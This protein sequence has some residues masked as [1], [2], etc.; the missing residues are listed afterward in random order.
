MWTG[1]PARADSLTFYGSAGDGGSGTWSPSPSILDWLPQGSTSPVPWNNGGGTTAVF[2]VGTDGTYAVTVDPAGVNAAGITFNNSGYALGG[3]TINLAG[4]AVINAASSNDSIAAVLRGAGTGGVTYTGTT[5]TVTVTGANTYAGPTAITGGTLSIATIGNG[6]TAGSLGAS[7][8]AS[9]N[10]VLSGGTLLYTGATGTTDRGITFGGGTDTLNVSN[11][12]GVL[13]FGGQAVLNG[14]SFLK[15]GAGTVAFTNTAGTNMLS[16]G[17]ANLYDGTVALSGSTTFGGALYLGNNPNAAQLNS[18]TP[19]L[20]VSAGTTTITSAS[21]LGYYAFNFNNTVVSTLN[22]TNTGVVKFLGGLSTSVGYAAGSGGLRFP[23]ND[24]SV[25]NLSGSGQIT[26]ENVYLDTQNATGGTTVNMSGS[27]TFSAGFMIVGDTGG[28]AGSSNATF[29]Q[30]GGT[31]QITG[32]Y[33]LVIAQNSISQGGDGYPVYGVYNLGNGPSGSALLVAPGVAGGQG[34]STFNINNGILQA[35]ANSSSSTSLINN[36][37]TANIMAGGAIINSNGFNVSIPQPL[38]NGDGGTGGLT[39]TGAGTLI[40]SGSN[41]YGGTTVV[42]GGTLQLGSNAAVPSGTA[43]TVNNGG[44]FAFGGVA[45]EPVNGTATGLTLGGLNAAAGSSTLFNLS[46]ASADAVAISSAANVASG[47]TISLAVPSGVSPTLG[48]YTLFQDTAGGL[49]N[50][51]LAQST[52]TMPGVT[53]GLSLAATPKSDI[54][55]ISLLQSS[56]YYFTGAAGNSLAAAGNY[57]LDA[58]GTIAAGAVPT[59]GIDVVFSASNLNATNAATTLGGLTAV[60][61]LDFNTATAITVAG[62]GTLSLTGGAVSFNAGTGIV[63]DASSAAPTIS[64][65]LLLP[66]TTTFI[67]NANA[68][69]AGPALISGVISDNSGSTGTASG[70]TLTSNASSGAAGAFNLSGANTFTGPVNVSGGANLIVAKFNNGL[71]AGPLGESS[72]ASSNVLLTNG[73]TLT[74]TGATATTDRGITFGVPGA[75]LAPN[76][77]NVSSPAATLTFASPVVSNPSGSTVL[78]GKGTVALA[79]TSAANTFGANGLYVLSGGLTLGPGTTTTTGTFYVGSNGPSGQYATVPANAVVTLNA[80]SLTVSGTNPLLMGQN[81]G[82]SHTDTLNLTNGSVLSVG[83]TVNISSGATSGQ[84]G[85]AVLTVSGGSLFNSSSTV[86][87]GGDNVTASGA[88]GTFNLSDTSRATLGSASST[89]YVGYGTAGSVGTLNLTGSGNVSAGNLDLGESSPAAGG[90]S[91]AAGTLNL[92][93]TSTLTVAGTLRVGDAG[94]GTVNQSGGAILAAGS[95]YIGAGSSGNFFYTNAGAGVLNLTGGTFN[96]SGSLYVG[97]FVNGV[98]NQAAGT[99]ASGSTLYLGTVS[100]FTGTYNLGSGAGS[101]A[102]LI[103]PAVQGF[104]PGESGYEPDDPTAAEFGTSTFNFNGGTLQASASSTAFITG[105]TTVNVQGG[106]AIINTNGFAETIAQNL[107]AGSSGSGGLTKTGVGTLTLSGSNTYAGPTAV[108]AGTLVIASPGALPANTAVTVAAGTTLSVIGQYQQSAG[109]TTP[110]LTIGSLTL[111]GKGSALT[112]GLGSGTADFLGVSA[113]AN[114]GSGSVINVAADGTGIIPAPGTYTLLSDANGGLGTSS[115]T[116]GQSAIVVNG[117]RYS[118]SLAG[119][120]SKLEQLTIGAATIARL[121]FQGNS[122]NLLSDPA[123]YTTDAAGQTLANSAPSS[124]SDVVFT[125]PGGIT[126]NYAATLGTTTAVNSL[127]FNTSTAVRVAGTGPLSLSANAGN[128]AAGT[129]IVVDAGATAPTVSANLQLTQTTTFT[130]NTNSATAGQLVLSGVISNTSSAGLTLLSNN[131]A[132]NVSSGGAFNL[133][134]AN[135][136]TGPTVISTGANLIAN[137][138][139]VGGTASSIGASSNASS[140][141]VLQNGGTLTYIGATA[142][143]DR[144]F[145]VGGGGNANPNLINVSSPS[146]VLTLGGPVVSTGSGL[147]VVLGGGGLTLT[148]TASPSVNTFPTG[149]LYVLNGTT[150]FGPGTVNVDAGTLRIGNVGPANQYAAQNGNAV[151]T[152]NGASFNATGGAFYMSLNNGASNTT[153]LNLVNGAR[154]YTNQASSISG[155]GGGNTGSPG[156][157]NGSQ[158]PAVINVSGGSTFTST[159]TTI[160]YLGGDNTVFTG[161]TATLNVFDTSSFNVSGTFYVGDS[162]SGTV[163]QYGGTVRTGSTVTL[164]VGV[165]S[166]GT[167]NLGN[168]NAGSGILSVTGSVYGSSEGP[169]MLNFN[170][171]TLQANASSTSFVKFLTAANVLAGGATIDTQGYNVSI[172]QPLLASTTSTGGGLTTLGTGTLTLTGASTYTGLTSVSATGTLLVNG[173]I[174]AVLVPAG[175]TLGGNGSVGAV[176]V[177]G[178]ITAG[179]SATAVGNFSTGMQTWNASGSYAPKLVGTTSDALVMSGLMVNASSST[180]F[181]INLTGTSAATGAG[182]YILAVDKGGSGDAFDLGPSQTLTPAVSA[183]TLKVNGSATAVPSNYTLTEGSDTTGQGGVDLILSTTVA[184][185]EPTSLLLLAAAG[186]P[187]GLGRRRRR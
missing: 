184:A 131:T 183:L 92:T 150:T 25:I 133:S 81:D 109:S 64:A 82:P 15:T 79:G 169:A 84:Q 60:N 67:N 50:F 138:I 129:G 178:K 161:G 153:T 117:T 58:G 168:G 116:L 118:L 98:V 134:G 33:P 122:S 174:G 135:T 157:A 97:Y 86:Y 151:L 3:G 147:L 125:S 123:N 187:L 8:N 16:A 167:Y 162:G 146:T 46:S 95:A 107:S 128:F 115:F 154:F 75:G 180:P 56:R 159:S 114:I 38:M 132:T 87:I 121:F 65:G 74:Y 181:I 54:L 51:R 105:I 41:S 27:S 182:S 40:L 73:G 17:Q 71:T 176:T 100:T 119:S 110:A 170:G 63:I 155:T 158:G 44:T 45:L 24:S 130:N 78:L 175:G 172:P 19:T 177:A 10:L 2:G 165:N 127:E 13:T 26:A 30:F 83:G 31:V 126:S 96:T 106:G 9:S 59:S 103:A 70:L 111:A 20:N 11:P 101:T 80:A 160:F 28:N 42:N 55:T 43:V 22:V 163:N 144:G 5:G 57:A 156:A 102:T 6:G 39:K 185:P 136:Y 47:A 49:A 61:A 108:A 12:A 164:A 14:G 85:V 76:V 104:Q 29:N 66:Q 34:D 62:P 166:A 186:S 145:T 142:V 120:T 94:N 149:G 69:S 37:T 72:N 171:G 137:T 52:Y 113:T 32:K 112:F 35:S 77:L 18:D 140:N 124:G 152:L 1:G 53:Y 48:S 88:N 7:S 89:A 143:S 4:G 179:G 173:S 21:Y 90:L 23:T 139:A 91:G 148:N 141:L 36:L 68:S 93:G 99:V